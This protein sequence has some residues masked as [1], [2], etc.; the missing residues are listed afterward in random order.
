MDVPTFLTVNLNEST[1]VAVVFEPLAVSGS[2]NQV[3]GMVTYVKP[4]VKN[5]GVVFESALKFDKQVNAVVKSIIF[6]LRPLAKVKS[7]FFYF[8]WVWENNIGLQLISTTAT[9]FI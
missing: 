1:T 2:W 8:C 4:S 6:Q 3:M 7:F 9:Q 5:V